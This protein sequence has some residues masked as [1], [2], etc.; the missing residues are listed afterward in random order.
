MNKVCSLAYGHDVL[1][2]QETHGE[3]G[4]LEQLRRELPGYTIVG[5]F[6]PNAATAG[7]ITVI[8][9]SLRDRFAEVNFKVL[10]PGRATVTTLSA[11]DAEL[12]LCNVHVPPDGSRGQINELFRTMAEHTC[13]QA[14]R[15]SVA[16]G[17]WNC[18]A[19]EADRTTI[20]EADRDRFS[21]DA[22]FSDFCQA[23]PHLTEVFQGDAT[24]CGTKKGRPDRFSRLDRFYVG[25]YAPD[26]IDARPVARTIGLA[27]DPRLGSDHV[28]IA[29]MLARPLCRPAGPRRLLPAL[30]RSKDFQDAVRDMSRHINYR[31]TAYDQLAQLIEIFRL[32]EQDLRDSVVARGAAS[33]YHLQLHFCLVLW[34][35]SRVGDA[36]RGRRAV[37]A[38][39]ALRAYTESGLII[40][41]PGFHAHMAEL[42]DQMHTKE[43]AEGARSANP[44]LAA[45][46]A[47]ARYGPWRRSRKVV[48]LQA[49]K[50]PAGQAI[51]SEEEMLRLLREHW[52]P[53]FAAPAGEFVEPPCLQH[54]RPETGW[55]DSPVTE[56]EV[57]ELL[58][59]L[60]GSAPGP[61][62]V[63]YVCYAAFP[64]LVAPMVVDAVH[65]LFCGVTPPA[66]FNDSLLVL[67]P[68]GSESSDAVAVARS[69]GDVRPLALSN[70]IQKLLAKLVAN[71]LA[72]HAA[73]HVRPQQ[74]GFVKG[75]KIEEAVLSVESAGIIAQASPGNFAGGLFLDVKAAF[76]SIY[77][78][79]IW[80]VL[81][82]RG[83]PPRLIRAL[84][85]L[86]AGTSGLLRVRAAS[87][88]VALARGVKQGCPCSG[89]VWALV[90]DA[91]LAAVAATIGPMD[92]VRA[93]ADDLGIICRN[94]YVVLPAIIDLFLTDGVLQGLE[95]NLKKTIL[96]PLHEAD[97]AD[98][99]RRLRLLR[100]CLGAVVVATHVKYLGLLWGPG[101]AAIAWKDALQTFRARARHIGNIGVTAHIGLFYYNVFAQ[102]TLSFVAQFRAPS[103]EVAQAEYAALGRA[104]SAPAHAL[105]CDLL[106]DLGRLGLKGR[107]RRIADIS[108]AARGR[109]AASSAAHSLAMADLQEFRGSSDAPLIFPTG[110]WFDHSMLCNIQGAVDVLEG[111]VPPI[112]V[113]A[114]AKYQAFVLGRLHADRRDD[115]LAVVARRLAR[116]GLAELARPV[117]DA[118]AAVGRSLP[119]FLRWACIRACTN[120]WPTARRFGQDAVCPMCR[121]AEDS[122]EHCLACPLA[123]RVLRSGAV[124]TPAEHIVVTDIRSFVRALAAGSVLYAAAVVDLIF[125]T[126]CSAMQVPAPAFEWLQSVM[127]ARLRALCRKAP[128]LQAVFFPLT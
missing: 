98:L 51:E 116:W 85:L 61:D 31:G 95:L 66:G 39:P 12:V 94:V 35:A 3:T 111:L 34:R 54:I 80:A 62:G 122:I 71:R 96:V 79:M 102:S 2:L 78:D 37:S 113:P 38:Y 60:P 69:P 17:D 47:R 128:A 48:S 4:D 106:G 21:R 114:N 43:L 53:I 25:L 112:I 6:G 30:V 75:R 14:R 72:R 73:R 65:S 91:M 104:L 11:D 67:L 103:G 10:L 55:D 41:A 123:L 8:R 70:T 100:R 26:L 125:L 63:P 84:R 20:A 28:P 9:P 23:L 57:R 22:R 118:L 52:E 109:L 44:G 15:L 64:E 45:D 33:A 108:V 92:T 27:G 16:A 110:W 29:M 50:N 101:A 115:A 49:V 13:L 56:A 83:A 86:Y 19:D 59:R 97:P 119:P 124:G 36:R 5:S 76:P 46:A 87:V 81:R 1:F 121:G 89:V 107:F 42:A 77:P 24:R 74:R 82:R 99:R 58:R 117:C 40:D 105:P 88:S 120:A 93:Y 127:R 18:V 90:F 68:K 32:A 7:V 126:R